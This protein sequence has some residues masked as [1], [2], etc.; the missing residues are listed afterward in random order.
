MTRIVEWKF[1]KLSIKSSN[2]NNDNDDNDYEL[3]YGIVNQQS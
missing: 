1:K 2:D 3:F